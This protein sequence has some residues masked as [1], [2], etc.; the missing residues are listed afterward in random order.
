[1]SEPIKQED[2]DRMEKNPVWERVKY[3][4]DLEIAKGQKSLR[5]PGTVK[6]M[7][8]EHV[9]YSLGIIAGLDTLAHIMSGIKLYCE[10]NQPQKGD[11]HVE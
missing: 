3:Y 4:V 6:A 1:M 9:R 7:T 5:D 8:N 11:D 2:I 10:Q